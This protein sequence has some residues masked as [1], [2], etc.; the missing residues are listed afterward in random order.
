MT[1]PK[2]QDSAE[3]ECQLQAAISAY[4]NK[5][6]TVT[7]AVRYYDVPCA[8]FYKRLN[9]MPPR[10]QAQE[11]SQRLMNAEEKELVWWITRLTITVYLPRYNTLREMAEAILKKHP[12]GQSK[13][14]K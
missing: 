14:R 13:D 10:N 5:V 4:K 1:R 12:H 6:K 8:T 9:G 7:A 2:N 3:K 11:S